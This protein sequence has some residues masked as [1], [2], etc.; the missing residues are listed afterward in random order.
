LIQNGQGFL[1]KTSSAAPGQLTI[2]ESDKTF[3]PNMDVFRTARNAS[4]IR[5]NLQAVN[6]DGTTSLLDEVFSSYGGS[7]SA[8]VDNMDASKMPNIEENLAIVNG[9]QL[10]M[11]ERRPGL[12][13]EDM[14]QL[15]M[16]NAKQKT[17]LL[18]FTPQ[19][20]S[21][22]LSAWVVDNYLQT[23]TPLP[24]DKVSNIHFTVTADGASGASDR[25]KIVMSSKKPQLLSNF[26]TQGIR[27]Y[28]NPV[29]GR[30]VNLQF[31][32]TPEGRYQLKVINNLGQVVYKKDIDHKAGVNTQQLK[33]DETLSKGVYQL[34]VGNEKSKASIKLVVN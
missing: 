17:Y 3:T 19:N 6:D 28:P 9:D 20:L 31:T 5:I 33:L 23:V 12:L 4:S 22:A 2:K 7:F 32:N 21:S 8:K 11:V 30:N 29:E 14:I 1:V 25:F 13:E 34:Q 26:L 15:K 16:W 24:L 10:L 18:E 27:I